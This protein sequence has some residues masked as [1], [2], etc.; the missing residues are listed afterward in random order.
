[1]F[2][3]YEKSGTV[4]VRKGTSKLGWRIISHLCASLLLLFSTHTQ[5]AVTTYTDESTYLAALATLA[6]TATVIPESFESG[7][8][9]PSKIHNPVKRNKPGNHLVPHRRRFT[10]Q[11]RRRRRPSRLLFNVRLAVQPAKSPGSGRLQL[12]YTHCHNAWCWWLVPRHRRQAVIHRRW[13][14]RMSRISTAKMRR[15]LTRG[16]FLVLS[17]PLL[18]APSILLLAMRLAMKRIYSLPM[19]LT[20]LPRKAPASCSLI[21]PAIQLPKNGGSVTLTV[22]R[23]RW[24]CWRRQC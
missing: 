3:I 4:L 7:P 18:S 22:T 14:Y 16:S 17:T 24:Q 12:Q 8:W 23:S 20:L 21:L 2:R 9:I 11:H 13:L 15:F 5:A 19:I 6:P 1:M 10:Y